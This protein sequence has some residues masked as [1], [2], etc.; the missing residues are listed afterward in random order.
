MFLVFDLR[1]ARAH[2]ANAFQKQT[3]RNPHDVGFVDRRQLLAALG[4]KREALLGNAQAGLAR[5]LAGGERHIRGG[6]VFARAH[7][8]R[9]VGIE[10]LGVLTHDHQIELMS[11]RMRHAQMGARGADIGEQIQPDAQLTRRV[12]P[13]LRLLRIVVVRHRAEHNA[14]RRLALLP[15]RIWKR[16]A[17]GAQRVKADHRAG[18]R[19][20]KLKPLIRRTQHRFGR[21]T[22][23]RADAVPI[24]NKQVQRHI[25][26]P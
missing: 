17:V 18:E 24:Q 13:A 12:Q 8:H 19:Q 23:F 16:R 9:A 10:P 4:G 26:Q 7:E 3:V 25:I 21:S 1:I 15:R 2:F 22:D 5:H 6:H 11:A 20:P 14:V